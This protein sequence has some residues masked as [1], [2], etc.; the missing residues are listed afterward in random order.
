MRPTTYADCQGRPRPCPWLSCKHNLM[1]DVN[2]RTGSL[3]PNLGRTVGGGSRD[4]R[5]LT[6]KLP[7]LAERQSYGRAAEVEAA[8][9]EALDQAA[10]DD[11]PTCVLDA[12]RD[13]QNYTLEEVGDLLSVTRERVRQIEIGALKQIRD[14]RGRAVAALA[15]WEDARADRSGWESKL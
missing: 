9:L 5:N 12:V 4:R 3:I 11:A 10:A 7:N 14:T 2:E 13:G 6:R 8:L 15:D 1:L